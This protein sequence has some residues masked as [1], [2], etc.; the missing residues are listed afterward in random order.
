MLGFSQG[1]A[2]AWRWAALGET[3]LERTIAWGSDVPPDVPLAERR[4]RLAAIKLQSV[5]GSRDPLHDA[6]MVAR[7]RGRLSELGLD[8]EFIEFPGA[9]VIE[10]STLARLSKPAHAP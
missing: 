2:T 3:R 6:A 9:H 5:R 7:D 10:A 8:C 1:A 4:A